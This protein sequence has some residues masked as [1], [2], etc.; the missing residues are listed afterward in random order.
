MWGASRGS[1]FWDMGGDFF[2]RDIKIHADFFHHQL[3]AVIT[4]GSNFCCL[5]SQT[6]VL[7][8]GKIT[9]KVQTARRHTRAWFQDLTT[10]FNRGNHCHSRAG[11][12]LGGFCPPREGV[13]VTQSQN[14]DTRREGFAHE[15]RGAIGAIRAGGV[16]VKI[17]LQ[18]HSPMLGG[19]LVTWRKTRLP[20]VMRT[21]RHPSPKHFGPSSRQGGHSPLLCLL[22]RGRCRAMLQEG[23]TKSVG[24]FL[25]SHSLFLQAHP[26]SARM[27]RTILSAP[28]APLPISQAGVTAPH[29]AASRSPDPLPQDTSGNW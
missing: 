17:N 12:R 10:Q 27:T 11:N 18:R 1:A 19:R 5:L 8:V 26:N 25:G 14:V 23:A 21:G 24:S 9:Q 20:R 15:L 16:G 4:V 2:P 28:T 29:P 22:V 13:V 7:G 6:R 3:Q